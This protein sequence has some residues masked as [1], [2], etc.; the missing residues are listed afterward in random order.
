MELFTV[1]ATSL[2][3]LAIA[4]IIV[5]YIFCCGVRLWIVANS[6]QSVCKLLEQFDVNEVNERYEDIKNIFRSLDTVYVRKF[7][8]YLTRIGIFKRHNR[9]LVALKFYR[10]L[11]A[12]HL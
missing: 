9:K 2:L 6:L 11:F 8:T 4:I 10:I 12:V 1:N 3:S 7:F 5:F